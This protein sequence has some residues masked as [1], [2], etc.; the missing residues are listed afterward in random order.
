MVDQA[1]L[2]IKLQTY[3]WISLTLGK[4]DKTNRVFNKK[5]AAGTTLYDLFA[6]LAERHPEFRD[7]VYN[8]ATGAMNEQILV[9]I[10]NRL[11]QARDFRQ[12]ELHDQDKITLSL[13]LAGG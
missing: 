2:N 3:S 11:V 13:V 10:N 4:T 8:P 9:I 7:K 6:N 1:V 12:T 5:I